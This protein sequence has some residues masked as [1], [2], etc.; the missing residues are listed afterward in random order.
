MRHYDV[1]VAGGGPAGSTVATLVKLYSP[2]LRVL[3]LEKARFPRHHIGESLLAGG[4]PVLREMG[5][6]EKVNG[7][8]F[9]EKL[10]AT[11][12]WGRDRKPWGFEFDQVVAHLVAQG[13]TLPELYTKGW[14]V[15]RGEYDQLLL[16]NATA[17][18]VEVRQ[19]ARV[20]RAIMDRASGRV[21]GV[22]FEDDQ[23]FH[24]VSCT[25]LMDCTG[26]DALLGRTLKLRE[27]DP[28]MNNYALWGYWKNAKWKIE[29]LGHP[30]LTRIFVASTPRGWIWYIPAS[31]DVVS[32]GFVTHRQ[33][34]KEMSVR[35]EQLYREELNACAEIEGLLEG[36]HLVRIA[37][38][39][40]RDVCVIQ[41]WSYN[42]RQMS[43]PGWALAGDAAG[44]VDPILS[45]GVMLAHEL[46]QKAAYAI[47]SSFQASSDAQVCSYWDFYQDTC[48]TYLQAYR[49]MAAFWYS[50]NF[51]M[52]SWW[53]EAQ[54]TLAQQESSVNLT[55][56]EAFNRLASGYANRAESISLFGSYPLHEAQQ[57]V[58]G[59]FGVS[60]NQTARA[61]LADHQP[62][63]SDKARVTDGMYFYQ[64]FVRK[65]RRVI[66]CENRRYLDLHP[67]EEVLLRMMDGQHT[68]ADVN[69]AAED[70]GALNTRLPVRSG[71][72]LVVQLDGIGALAS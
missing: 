50:N 18:D 54:R 32:V 69:R 22:E 23:G 66:N 48:Q 11:Y 13:K 33:T 72:D 70:I 38:D 10:G 8:G 68:L 19:G 67:A 17:K 31:R 41:D 46:G 3:V 6:Y 43:G 25:W 28:R 15:T 27:Y 61:N 35:P 30:H 52:E 12:V 59:L 58:D 37:P 71:T 62:R 26:Q 14:Q 7:F 47:N 56:R 2:H 9:P 4:T 60:S 29:Y 51:T 63:L 40:K 45:A 57:L 5:V 44:F 34:L 64:G 1:V 20:H 39:Q 36:A 21:T 55:D 65:T 49:D 42:S 16:E 24:K 53:W